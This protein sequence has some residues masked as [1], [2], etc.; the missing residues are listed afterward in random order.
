MAFVIESQVWD[1]QIVV[2]RFVE[3][4]SLTIMQKVQ[5]FQG[6]LMV[7]PVTNSPKIVKDKVKRGIEGFG[8]ACDRMRGET[9]IVTLIYDAPYFVLLL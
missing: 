1:D 9:N 2:G 5:D 3:P 6:V 7:A 8:I 4:L